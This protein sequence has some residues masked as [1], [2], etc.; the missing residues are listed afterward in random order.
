MTTA[1]DQMHSSSV[2]SK[3]NQLLSNEP[4]L[5]PSI[6]NI[7]GVVLRSKT[8]DFERIGNYTTDKSTKEST[9]KKLTT[10]QTSSLSSQLRLGPLYRRRELI[11]SQ[12][13]A[14]K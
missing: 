7:G 11:S 8:A 9:N 10:P 13:S 2:I 1:T 14:K 5:T 6:T 12:Q 3:S 4:K